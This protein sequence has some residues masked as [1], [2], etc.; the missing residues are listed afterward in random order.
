MSFQN[1]AMRVTKKTEFFVRKN[2]PTILTGV[3]VAGF[4]ATTALTIRATAKAV[5][6]LPIISKRVQQ[7][8]DEAVAEEMN[9]KDASTA[10][11]KAYV[12]NA[13]MVTKIYGPTLA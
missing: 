7:A 13:L 8:R 10:L 11:A 3:G 12:E 2:A 5:D 1:A 9:T 6:M 4:V